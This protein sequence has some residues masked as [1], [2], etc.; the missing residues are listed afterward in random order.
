MY[1]RDQRSGDS[2]TPRIAINYLISP[3]HGLRA[4]YSQAVRSPDM[5]ENDANWNYRVRDIEPQP[6]GQS[7]ASYFVTTPGP[8]NLQQE[9][10]G[11]WELGYNG[12]S[13]SGDLNLDIKLFDERI[14]DMISEPLRNG[15]APPSNDN[16]MEFR[17]AE[18][19]LDWQLGQADRL[20]LSYAYVDFVASSELD[21]RLTARHSGSVGWLRDWGQGWSSGL[22]YY[23]ADQLNRYRFERMDLRI[24]K[25]IAM[26]GAEL[27]LAAVMQQRLDDEPLTWRENNRDERQLLY[28]SAELAF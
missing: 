28:F 18:S 14:D 22:F 12:Q 3:R 20:R 16:W 11:S 21:Q 2:L 6:F 19:Q 24:A 9:R 17:G 1:E 10:I 15:S 23:G 7:D 5:L 25:R 26:G 13:A 27:E 8:G 4:V